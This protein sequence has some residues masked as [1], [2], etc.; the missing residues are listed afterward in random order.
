VQGNPTPV[1]GASSVRECAS[2]A[3]DRIALSYLD[4]LQGEN[5]ETVAQTSNL[6]DLQAAYSLGMELLHHA[7][8]ASPAGISVRKQRVVCPVS[9][10]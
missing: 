2:S 4:T 8:V 6:T 3:Q 9:A 1:T 7:A 5:G 10:A